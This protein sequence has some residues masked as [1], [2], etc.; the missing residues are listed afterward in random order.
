[1]TKFYPG[2]RDCNIYNL[3]KKSRE[4]VRSRWG[5]MGRGGERPCLMGTFN[6][7]GHACASTGSHVHR[8]TLQGNSHP[9]ITIEG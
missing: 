4:V 5:A 3:N 2:K 8:V 1:M 6:T 7:L 9:R